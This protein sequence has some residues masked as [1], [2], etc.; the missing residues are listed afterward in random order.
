MPKKILLD[1]AQS[2]L[3]MNRAAIESQIHEALKDPSL[4]IKD[5]YE[6]GLNRGMTQALELYEKKEFY[7][8]ELIVCADT[9]NLGLS[10]LRSQG[11]FEASSSLKVSIAVIEGDTHEI[12]KNI[13]KVMLEAAGFDVQDLGVNNNYRDIIAKALEHESD[14]ICLS[15]MM[16]STMPH[17]GLVI[18]EL[19][20]MQE[21]GRLN[22]DR[23]PLVIVGGAPVTEQ[24]AKDIKADAYS[25]N[26]PETVMAIK[27]LLKDKLEKDKSGD[28][29]GDL[30]AQKQDKQADKN[31]QSEQGAQANSA[32]DDSIFPLYKR[33]SLM[34]YIN[35]EER[36]FFLPDMATNGLYLYKKPVYEVYKNPQYQL[37][38]AQL[39][40]K[41]F[42]ADFIYSLCDGVI[43]S[44]ACGLEV[45]K[46][47]YD[48]PSVASHPITSIEKLN[49]LEML[50]PFDEQKAPRMA[51]NMK[52]L[53]AIAQGV[54]CPLYLSIQG[55]FTLAV[56][57]AGATHLLKSVVDEP[58]FVEALLDFTTELVYRYT[59]AVQK[60]GACLISVAEPATVT[61]DHGRFLKLVVPRLN[62]IYDALD[63]WTSLHICGDTFE[64]L[65]LMLQCHS[66]AISL[67]QVMDYQKVM[68]LIPKD[69]VLIGNLDP[70]S[71]LEHGS[72]EEIR[73]VS[74]KL[75]S[76]MR[77]YS[78]FL[79]AFG[80]NCTNDSPVE[81]LQAAIDIARLPYD[82]LDALRLDLSHLELDKK[83][84]LR[85]LGYASRE[86]PVPIEQMLDEELKTIHD[87]L[88]P[89]VFF[90]ELKEF[91][92]LYQ[93]HK[94]LFSDKERIFALVYT[95]GDELEPEIERKGRSCE[96]M[97]AYIDDK[98]G[99]C[100]LD[101]IKEA[102]IEHLEKVLDKS[103][104]HKKEFYPAYGQ[105]SLAD[106]TEIYKLVKQMNLS[107]PNYVELQESHQLN[108]VKSVAVL[109]AF[110][111]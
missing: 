83:R 77:P 36:G 73:L 14:V 72:V 19:N 59:Q 9:L 52:S 81:N 17:M 37:E 45:L 13:V 27:T 56:Q 105:L 20:K 66:D 33:M 32:Q 24:Y 49:E 100:A 62:K 1:I 89:Q 54:D 110:S 6:N 11:K 102:A 85:F 23:R 74:L 87:Y 21:D 90:A 96:M 65:D 3:N 18:K 43:L 69:K 86:V 58:E 95:L 53:A 97:R 55:P 104:A 35:S 64:F 63:T 22:P 94:A 76:D 91:H 101:A 29:S 75:C 70:I 60:S 88:K 79:C 44:E 4:S 25:S 5:I 7:L 39:M 92:D 109:L 26:A 61:L 71:L 8:P 15:S 46:P 68:P 67:D 51:T 108:P 48:F 107:L 78:N 103:Y 38:L 12:G 41:T 31:V 50:D 47:D 93:E 34:E 30:G 98:L 28:Q 106:Q 2:V 40:H 42:P 111:N 80:C 10:I 82:K 16:T 84:A 57:L 99:I